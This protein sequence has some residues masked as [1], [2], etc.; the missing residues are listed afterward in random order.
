ME[1]TGPYFVVCACPCT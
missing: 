1:P